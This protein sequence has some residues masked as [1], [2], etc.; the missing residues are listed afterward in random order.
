[1]RLASRP[2]RTPEGRGICHYHRRRTTQDA[3]IRQII[4]EENLIRSDATFLNTALSKGGPV[5]RKAEYWL[6]ALGG[7][8]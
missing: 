7:L 6:A 2:E 5:A 3:G 8:L 1:M 4:N